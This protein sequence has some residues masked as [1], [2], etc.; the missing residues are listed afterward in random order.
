MAYSSKLG[1][2]IKMILNEHNNW[3]KFGYQQWKLKKISEQQR[4]AELFAA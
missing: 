4:I 1:Y 3:V 2:D